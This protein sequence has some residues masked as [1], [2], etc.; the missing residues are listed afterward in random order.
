MNIN[1]LIEWIDSE[2]YLAKHC[3]C[4]DNEQKAIL[5]SRIA[6][7]EEVRRRIIKIFFCTCEEDE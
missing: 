6:T 3:T 4:Y 2:I 1:D 7:L 5:Y